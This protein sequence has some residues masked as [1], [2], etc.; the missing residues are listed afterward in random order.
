MTSA[1]STTRNET[2]PPTFT[3]TMGRRKIG[4]GLKQA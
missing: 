1:A 2:P 4:C 3:Q